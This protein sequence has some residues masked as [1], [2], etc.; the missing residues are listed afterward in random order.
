ML[1]FLIFAGQAFGAQPSA[2][3]PIPAPLRDLPWGQLNF[4]HT[5]DIH[6]W[7]GGHLREPQYS[8]DWGDY[9]S[10][11]QHL[12]DKADADGTDIIVVD[13]GDRVEG[14]GIYDASNPKG[15]Y[16]FDILKQQDIDVIC[17][18]NHELYKAGTAGNE[19]DKTV[20]DFKGH[21][22]ASNIDYFNP[23]TKGLEPLAPRYR[24]FTT[25]NQG[26]RVTAFGFLFDFTGNA[27]NTAVQ[28]VE[29]TVKEQWFQDAIRDKDVDIFLV[30]GHVPVRDSQEFDLIY[31]TIRAAQWD[32]PIQ[33]LGGHTHIRD[34]HKYDARAYGLESGRYF[35]TIGF[36]S[37]SGIS[38]GGKRAA[39]K[40]AKNKFARRYIDNN[41]FSL[42]H[43]S[44]RNASTFHT[45]HGRNV[46]SM[47]ADARKTL[48]LD[49][50][51]GCAPQDYWVNRVPY[52]GKDS[53]FT[54]LEE[55]VLPQQL[56]TY[57]AARRDNK[58]ALLLANTG[59]VR[60]DIFEGPFTQDSVYLVSPFTSGF[61]FVKN[62]PKA[63]AERV[64]PLL[65][66]GSPLGIKDIGSQISQHSLS[67]LSPP[68]VPIL[69]TPIEDSFGRYQDQIPIGET[70]APK[71]TDD[72]D[73]PPG[74]TTSDDAGKDGDD[75]EH[76]PIQF[77]N[78]PNCFST[79]FTPSEYQMR[80]T[81]DEEPETVDLV[82]NEFIESWVLLALDFLGQDYTREDTAP[83]LEGRSFTSVMT[84]WVEENWECKD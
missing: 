15:K 32:T 29:D 58:P 31:K 11:A 69:E 27:N 68:T 55:T 82:Y 49:K 54:W 33:F 76:A 9:V 22:I 19:F 74:Y 18:G 64:L 3:S 12:R 45:D 84:D 53:I 23:K 36:G 77:Y 52:P 35:E 7:L 70:G 30:A 81:D 1:S 41:L 10:F 62:V 6:G 42:Y 40:A 14:N 47:I 73:L 24:K 17:S 51:F 5:T 78:V 13:T 79:Y 66:N 43:H 83:Y 48:K 50:M 21:Y 80:D 67:D 57:Q 46:S 28:F 61:R 25:K 4:L 60:F 16:T 65:N 56:S 44:D 34:F 71:S 39:P 63:I 20:P 38:T 8:A 2:P 75:T 37:V 26:I 59:A 72:Q